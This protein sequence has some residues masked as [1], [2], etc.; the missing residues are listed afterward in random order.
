MAFDLVLDVGNSSVGGAF[1]ESSSLVETFHL[2]SRPLSKEKLIAQIKKRPVRAAMLG[3]DNFNAGHIAK[4]ALDELSIPYFFVDSSELSILLDVENP[5]EVGADRIANTYGA[6]YTHPEANSIVIDM[7]TAVTF[8]VIAKERRF[9]GG[10][11]YPGPYLSAKALSDAAD[12]LPVVPIEKPKSCLSRSTIGNIQSGLYYGLI[13]TIERIVKEIKSA[14][15][16]HSKV[17]VIATGGLTKSD[18]GP[19]SFLSAKFRMDLEND[20]KGLVDYFEPD[21]TLLGLHQMLLEKQE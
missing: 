5:E 10:A 11:I 7:G 3:A 14:R 4:E 16:S 6:L 12:K 15:F 1:F 2:S 20:L 19:D 18:L 17:V 9:L 21:L 8:D 13:G